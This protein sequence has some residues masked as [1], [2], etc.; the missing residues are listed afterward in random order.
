MFRF[1]APLQT[2]AQ[3]AAC[4]V[5]TMASEAGQMVKDKQGQEP[6][7]P[8]TTLRTRTTETVMTWLKSQDSKWKRQDLNL[9]SLAP[10]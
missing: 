2:P 1:T 4:A 3:T 5:N 7:P 8:A 9:G 6:F 10:E